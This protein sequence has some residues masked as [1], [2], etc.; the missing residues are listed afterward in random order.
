[1]IQAQVFEEYLGL[2]YPSFKVCDGRLYPFFRPPSCCLAS[3]L[4]LPYCAL[5]SF[6]LS[7]TLYSFEI[8]TFLPPPSLLLP[9]PPL[10][11]FFSAILRRRR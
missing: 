1:M 4:A 10:Y 9:L 7:P 6:G 2:K 3:P 11:R 5:S 8:P